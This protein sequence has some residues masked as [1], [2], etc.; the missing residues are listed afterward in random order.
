MPEKSQ[1][2]I[3]VERANTMDHETSQVV[4]GIQK[5]LDKNMRSH[6]KFLD[7]LITRKGNLLNFASLMNRKKNGVRPV[8]K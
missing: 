5:I 3:E 6:A 8:D 1:S 2:V 4:K 7:Q